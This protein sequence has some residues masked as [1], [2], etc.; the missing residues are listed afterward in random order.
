MTKTVE[1]QRK[2]GIDIIITAIFVVGIFMT[3]LYIVVGNMVRQSDY[4]DA[5]FGE[6]YEFKTTWTLERP[7]GTSLSVNLPD[8]I[9]IP[10]GEEIKVSTYLPNDIEDNQYFFI[11][12]AKQ[13]MKVYVDGDIRLSYSTLDKRFWG[14]TSTYRYLTAP[15]SA[16]DAGK[17]IVII[18]KSNSSYSGQFPGFY[19]GESGAFWECIILKNIP[20]LIAGLILF[21]LY[22]IVFIITCIYS[23]LHKKMID[24]FYLSLMGIFSC[25]WILC[26]LK[27]RQLYFENA[28]IAN[29]M[30]YI[31]LMLLPMPLL[32]Y[33]D[34]VQEKKYH[35]VY[36]II[37]IFSAL[38][39]LISP[40]LQVFGI[41]DFS[42]TIPASA[43]IFIVSF[44]VITILILIDIAHKNYAYISIAA[45][46]VISGILT[47]IQFVLYVKKII[48]FNGI[49]VAIGAAILSITATYN[50]LNTLYKNTKEQ[51]EKIAQNKTEANFLANMS[52]EIRTPINAIIGLDEL[53]LR[54]N[55][56]EATKEYAK[57][58]QSAGQTL[59]AIVNDVLD[60]SRIRSGRMEI[61]P[62]EYSLSQI[63][64][65]VSVMFSPK[66]LEKG[67]TLEINVD[68]NLPDCYYGDDV[69]I[70]QVINNLVSNAIKYTDYGFITFS[71]EG[72][73]NGDTEYLKVCVADTGIGI[74]E[75]DQDKL[76]SAF[77]R[78]DLQR[79][80]N[81]EGTGLG[82]AISS[83]LL[84]MMDSELTFK[85]A[86]GVGT[87]FTFVLP[88]KIVGNTTILEAKQLGNNT[89]IGK[90][91]KWGVVAPKARILVADDNE[92]N[93]KVFCRLLE[94]LGVNID[95][96]PNGLEAVGK[97][98]TDIYDIIFLDHMMPVMDGIEAL[99]LIKE[100]SDNPNQNTNIIAL[101][102]NAIG[103]AMERYTK[104]GFDGYISKPFVPGDL[105]S[106]II[107]LLPED[108][109]VEVDPK[110]ELDEEKVNEDSSESDLPNID[111]IDWSIAEV[112]LPEREL[113]N[114]IVSDFITT[115]SREIGYVRSFYEGIDK[116][117]EGALNEYRIK[118]HA[119][120]NSAALIGAMS[121]S[122]KAKELEFAARDEKTDVIN[123]KND[124]FCMEYLSLAKELASKM[125]A[126]ETASELKKIDREHLLEDIE[127]LK[128]AME[129]YDIPTLN[130]KME[131]LTSYYFEG[132]KKRYI[133]QLDEAVLE[134][135]TA[136]F[137]Q[138]I[139]ELVKLCETSK[140]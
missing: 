95:V 20:E 60:E 120:K 117:Q 80:R 52:H 125:G 46:V 4:E 3:I 78:L 2:F 130:D 59:L 14:K 56:N 102:A 48:Q 75:E 43:V 28:S 10:K 5:S 105:E 25:T 104:E 18:T 106:L 1:K 12:S 68:E 121:L 108:K 55:A 115:S 131:E 123:S 85:S 63:I 17:E 19:I 124:A 107:N 8:K 37:E 136:K 22:S 137:T 42:N 79:N 66:A 70:R 113:L 33:M 34:T 128:K 30:A 98:R 24:L 50:T 44:V 64:H 94:S 32:M 87:Q 93:V 99:H 41:L 38:N 31:M 27:I 39:I 16:A 89:K 103:G 129:I 91:G 26:N 13:D 101:T 11:A 6:M 97:S 82:L 139:D 133:D 15:L 29:D 53:I 127:V 21:A 119:L 92:L 74:R 116:G 111:G 76:F 65:E 86:Y 40:L 84:K 45:G 36:R 110:F 57:D 96:A 69:R 9:D 73:A 58:I 88:Q 140:E 134:L 112:N 132:D 47:V 62:V 72:S 114:S 81:I 100:D 135:N 122:E 71:I 77:E 67:L 83:S 35:V 23:I 61:V 126:D 118:V 7:D 49:N 109:L 54:E 51:A 138:A 90:H